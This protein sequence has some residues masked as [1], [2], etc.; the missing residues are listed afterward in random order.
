MALDDSAARLKSDCS[1]P[2]FPQ[3]FDR[4]D[5]AAVPC[6]QFIVRCDFAY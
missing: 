4:T 5:S 6:V 1:C 3:P 2:L